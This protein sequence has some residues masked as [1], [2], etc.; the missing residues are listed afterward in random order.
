[1]A[2][3]TGHLARPRGRLAL[4]HH[5]H[6]HRHRRLPRRRHHHCRRRRHPHCRRR[7][8]HHCRR[9]RHHHCRRRRGTTT[10]PSP[11]LSS[12][13]AAQICVNLN[14]KTAMAQQTSAIGSERMNLIFNSTTTAERQRA[15]GANHQNK[16]RNSSVLSQPEHPLWLKWLCNPRDS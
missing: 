10:R 15:R 8:H 5:R 7:R 6:C 16:T 12:W 3:K 9:R 4:R 13:P 1:M 2:Q 11:S 14:L